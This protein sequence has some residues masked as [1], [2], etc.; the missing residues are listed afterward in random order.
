MGKRT[1]PESR[2]TALQAFSDFLANQQREWEA[3][4]HSESDCDNLLWDF[5]RK[6]VL[7]LPDVKRRQAQKRDGRWVTTTERYERRTRERDTGQFD[8]WK[9]ESGED[10]Q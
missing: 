7:E 6:A 9:A 10:H 4:G 3:A 5:V 1:L 8:A 2:E